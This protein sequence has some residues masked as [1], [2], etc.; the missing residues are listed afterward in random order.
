MPKC[1]IPKLCKHKKRG[2][3]FAVID[4]RWVYFGKYDTAEA[5]EKY[6][7]TIAEWL[8]GGDVSTP[9]EP[10]T[11]VTVAEVIAKFWKWGERHYAEN[12]RELGVYR[13]ALKPVAAMYGSTLA[14]SFGP[15]ALQLVRDEMIRK[16]WARRNINRQI[17]RIRT[18]FKWAVAEE[19]VG[20]V[21]NIIGL[22]KFS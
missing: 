1:R 15:K 16:G 19:L 20:N 13:D 10:N 5:E 8:R 7:T 21:V 3:A 14:D 17:V 9:P 6:K 18:V 12:P 22:S 2:L 4:G 11:G